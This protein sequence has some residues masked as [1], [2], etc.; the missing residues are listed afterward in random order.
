MRLWLVGIAALL[1]GA[2]LVAGCQI[3]RNSQGPQL[4]PAAAD[5]LRIGSWN[6]HYILANQADGRW[7][8]GHWLRRRQPMANVFAALDADIVAFQEMESFAGG[9]E[10]NN[11]LTR[12]W[13]LENNPLYDVAAVGAWQNFP[14]TQPLLYRRELF[15]VVD[16]G[17][18]FFSTTP[19]QIY[20]RT[21]NGSYPAFASWVQFEHKTTLKRFRIVN[22]HLDYS[23]S[24]NREQSVA[25]I[26]S[27]VRPWLDAGQQVIIAGDL[28]AR[29][30][31]SLHSAIESTGMQFVPVHGSTYHFNLGI[32]LF[33]AID[34]FAYT[35]GLQPDGDAFVLRS[36][37]GDTWAS[38]HYPVVVDFKLP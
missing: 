16:Q 28:N 25:L 5:A 36:K 18:F 10:D 4:Q 9:N 7:G 6:V 33:G 11:N 23:D 12:D 37:M 30:G 22:V 34:H 35:G 2:T 38:D 3:L 27:R 17:W 26:I 8:T 1:L 13:L 32:N 19:D 24:D 21:F 14:S 20:S 29:F 15:N 31:S